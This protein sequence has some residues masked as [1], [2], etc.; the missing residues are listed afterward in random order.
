M[1]T[2]QNSNQKIFHKII[3]V[4]KRFYPLTVTAVVLLLLL[5]WNCTKLDTSDIGSDQLP[6]VDNVHTFADTL[7]LITTQGIFNDT[8]K[9]AL[10]NNFVIG[11]INNDPLFGTTNAS[12]YFQLKPD[13]YPY[14]FGNAGDT[15]KG[16][17]DVGLDSIVL[18]LKYKSFWGDSSIPVQL[19][20]REVS[21]Y[22]FVDSLY[23][24]H[25]INYAPVTGAVLATTTVDI[26]RL[27]DT[28]KYTNGR[29]YSINLI[30]IKLPMSWANTLFNRDSIANNPG[31]NAFYNDSIF[32]HTYHGLAVMPVGSAANSLIYVNLADTTTKLE[33]HFRKR[34]KGVID[35]TYQSL[36]LGTYTLPP[37]PTQPAQSSIANKIVRNRSGATMQFPAPGDLYIQTTPGSYVNISIPSLSSLNNRIIHRAELVI[38]QIP[39][40]PSLDEALS[41]PSF[42]YLDLKDTTLTDRWKPIYYD[43]NPRQPYDP[44][45]KS[46]FGYLPT[47]IDY[48]TFG[49]FRRAGTDKFGNPNKYY[50]FNITRYV[51]QIVTRHIPNYPLRLYAPYE[52]YYPQL[53]NDTY[54]AE[55]LQYGNNLA[56]GRVKV[57]SGSNADYK[58]FLRIIYSNL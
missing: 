52:V 24:E 40:L 47:T 6:A 56:A 19:E 43:L 37:T 48:L 18:C 31:N 17:S 27:G 12:A 53:G 38:Q 25:D 42:L 50:N 57:G 9:V 22:T 58:M 36:H 7:P 51:Q 1:P 34:N 39:N 26:R 54:P 4:Q 14:Y 49:G 8:T 41:V 13:F 21:D 16:Y 5:N 15:V 45:T 10:L 28:V 44:D 20:V 55:K 11:A 23:K 32:R 30:R 33:V 35:T 46:G 29:N 2:L 3:T